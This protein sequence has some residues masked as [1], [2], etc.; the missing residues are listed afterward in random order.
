VSS[1]SALPGPRGEVLTFC[2]EDGC[3][4]EVV[5]GRCEEHRLKVERAPGE[6]HTKH[7]RVRRAS[8]LRRHPVCEEAGCTEASVDVHHIDGRGPG[9]SN[10]D[11]NLEALCKSHHSR[12]TASRMWDERSRAADR[13]RTASG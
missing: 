5:S 9:G 12:I 7:W 6:Y 1:V 10:A 2:A 3:V 13:G 8:Y 11:R 4:N